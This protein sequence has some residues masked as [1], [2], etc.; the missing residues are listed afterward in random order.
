MIATIALLLQ[1]FSL[2]PGTNLA[3]CDPAKRPLSDA[4]MQSGL[5]WHI[6]D[7]RPGPAIGKGRTIEVRY[8][9]MEATGASE[10]DVSLLQRRGRSYWVLWTHRFLEVDNNEGPKNSRVRYRW[11]Y[12]PRRERMIVTG[13]ESRGGSYDLGTGD[14]ET[15]VTWQLPTE[16]YCY[17]SSRGQFVHC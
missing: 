2:V 1:L 10:V 17:S 13:T 9:T 14:G 5:G 3:G 6:D 16:E 11:H 4:C 12:E 7:V 15:K 8:S